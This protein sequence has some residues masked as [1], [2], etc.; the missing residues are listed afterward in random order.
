MAGPYREAVA[1]EIVEAPTREGTAALEVAP[2][3]TLL[4]VGEQLTLSVTERFAS[5][6]R[7]VRNK[8]RKRSLRLQDARLLVA[9]AV[10]TDDIGIWHE[11]KPGVVT[12]LFGLHKH[13][14][15]SGTDLDELEQQWRSLERLVNHLTRALQTHSNGVERAIEVGVGADR[16]LVMDFGDRLLFHVRRLFRERQRKAFEVHRDGTIVVLPSATPNDSATV[17]RLLGR[18]RREPTRFV[19][20][21]RYGVSTS[22]DYI[23]FVGEE[24]DDLGRISLPWVRPEDRTQLARIITDAIASR[25]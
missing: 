19:C 1:A 10:P 6:T 25:G 17:G 24:G 9:R 2:R 22:G 7:V 21:F 5:V 20:R 4:K 23:R 8:P 12:R 15:D 16:V 11:H 18:I 13:T 3:H 14:L